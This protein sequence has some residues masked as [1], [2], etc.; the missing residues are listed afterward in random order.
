MRD[1]LSLC[2]DRGLLVITDD[3]TASEDFDR[4]PSV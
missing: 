2:N 3:T 4:V 1:V